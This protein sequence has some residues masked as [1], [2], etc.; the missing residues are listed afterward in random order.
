MVVIATVVAIV[1]VVNDNSGSPVASSPAKP[2]ATDPATTTPHPTTTAPASTLT[3]QIP[4]YQVDVPKDLKAAWDIPHDWNIDQ[5]TTVFGASS[6]SIP[7]VGF[8]TEGENYCPNNVRTSMFLTTSEIDDATAAATDVGA[9]AARIGYSTKTS[10]TP[11]T[12]QPLDAGQLHGTFL[13]TSGA[14][15]AP[16]GCATTYSVYTFAIRVGTGKGSLV[17]TL[18]SDTG[19]DRSVTPDFARKLFATFRL[20]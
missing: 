14:F 17:L 2:S 12:A 3:P 7:A 9:H 16:A 13:E 15:T 11:G 8:A 5:T 6:D 1:V 18:V 20:L 19:V 10:L 4:G